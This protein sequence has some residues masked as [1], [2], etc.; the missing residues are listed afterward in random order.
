MIVRCMNPLNQTTLIVVNVH[1]VVG[2]HNRYREAQLL[3][4]LETVEATKKRFDCPAVL[5]CGDFN[6]H[7]D[8]PEIMLLQ[9]F[10]YCDSVGSDDAIEDICT[11]DPQN[12]NNNSSGQKHRIDYIFH[13]LI[14]DHHSSQRCF[15]QSPHGSDHYGVTT[16][17]SMKVVP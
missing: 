10:G 3:H 16:R 8:E 7:H 4:I 13:S 12:T 14:F 2:R 11:W 9:A 5:I 6:A 17:L 1:L 15:D